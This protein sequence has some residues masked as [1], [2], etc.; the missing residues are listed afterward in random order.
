MHLENIRLL[1]FKNYAEQEASFSGEINCLLGRNGSGKT[2][3]LDAMHY[4]SLTRSAFNL[5]DQQNIRHGESAFSI[6]GVF[7]LGERRHRLVIGFEAGQGKRL[8]IDGHPVD[9]ASELVGRFP[10]VLISPG[11][12]ALVQEGAEV[13]RRFV[14]MM[15]AQIDLNYLDELARY[16]RALR[17]RNGLLK[18]LHSGQASDRDL[19]EPYD[20]LLAELGQSLFRRR[21]E[22]IGLFAPDVETHYRAIA[23]ATEEVALGYRSDLAQPDFAERYAHNLWQDLHLQ[24]TVMGVHRD[25]LRFAIGGHS[26]KRYGSQGQ[27]KSFVVALKL[28]QYDILRKEKGFK[29]LM[30]LDDIFDK[31]DDQRIGQ[32]TDLMAQGEFGQVFITDARPERTRHFLGGL[33]ADIRI[34]EIKNGEIAT[35]N[36]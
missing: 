10:V 3:L 18:M 19:L 21:S 24:R 5:L 6:A 28:A 1:N 15:L 36:F 26:L 25:D 11:D 29:P 34:Y 23:G 14:D 12:Q 30:L 32:L 2:N 22:F 8:E 13:R 4:L 35:G 33:K 16:N 9:K 7:R 20:R 31:L 17:Q 27:Q